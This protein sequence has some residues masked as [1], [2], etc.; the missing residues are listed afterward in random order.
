[1]TNVFIAYVE[2]D[3][4]RYENKEEVDKND[5]NGAMQIST[6]SKLEWEKGTN[7]SRNS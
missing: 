7:G 6:A 3:S 4:L 5:L 2:I 1:M